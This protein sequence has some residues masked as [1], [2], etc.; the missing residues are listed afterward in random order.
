MDIDLLEGFLHEAS[1]LKGYRHV[2]VLTPIGVVWRAGNR[3][4]VVLPFMDKGDLCD[5]IKKPD[6]VSLASPYLPP[7][8]CVPPSLYIFSLSP[9]LSFHSSLP[10]SPPLPTNSLF[11]FFCPPTSP[12]SIP[13]C[14]A[15]FS[16]LLSPLSSSLLLLPL[17][18]PHP[19]V[20]SH[21]WFSLSSYSFSFSLSFFYI[22]V[23][24][25]SLFLFPSPISP[26]SLP[27]PS[28][29]LHT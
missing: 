15:P 18:F 4:Q 19:S 27:L 29:W 21:S 14:P 7:F 9:F 25:F 1:F 6:I 24:F 28:P 13:L 26:L 23:A 11:P 22:S 5:L 10:R 2:N 17:V 8:L 3:P 12:L 16:L 20:Y